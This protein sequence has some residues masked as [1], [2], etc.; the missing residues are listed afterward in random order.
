MPQFRI[1]A[2]LLASLLVAMLAGCNTNAP[3]ASSGT[4]Y[5]RDSEHSGGGGGGGGGY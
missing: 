2:I 3:S 4:Q 5:Q 1:R